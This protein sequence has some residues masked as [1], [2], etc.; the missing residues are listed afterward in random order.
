MDSQ[1]DS[2]EECPRRSDLMQIKKKT[3]KKQESKD[4]EKEKPSCKDVDKQR[5]SQ[6]SSKDSDK[7]D[8]HE[9]I[10]QF[11]PDPGIE[12]LWPPWTDMANVLVA[13]D[14]KELETFLEKN[15]VKW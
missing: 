3:K 1:F 7:Q 2:E 8:I 14:L 15:K 10:Q 13:K 5:E 12:A 9:R 4:V 6:G 11:K